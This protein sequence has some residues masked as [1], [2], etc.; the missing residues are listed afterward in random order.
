[1]ICGV[2]QG[3]LSGC[4]RK[5]GLPKRT[6]KTFPP[7]RISGWNMTALSGPYPQELPSSLVMGI[8]LLAIF[9]GHR[10]GLT[11]WKNSVF[12]IEPKARFD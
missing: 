1:M 12:Y 3:S 4:I 2:T 6:V 11:K 8:L 7:S 10:G 9:E 5:N